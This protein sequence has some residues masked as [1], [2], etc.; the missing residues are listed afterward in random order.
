MEQE[1]QNILKKLNV[2]E[3]VSLLSGRDFWGTTIIAEKG[4]PG[5]TVT[6][7]PHG[8]RISD[9]DSDRDK[10]G[11]ATAFPT[12]VAMAST[13]NPEL[14]HKVGVALAEETRANKCDILL[15]P[16]INI[17]RTPLAGRNFETFSEDPYL[18]GQMGI[19]YVQ[20]VQSRGVGVSV[21][22]FA[23]NNQE[24]RRDKGSSN[25]DERTLR[26]IYL[27]A[28]EMIVKEADPWTIMCSYNR[29]NGVYASE[30]YHLLTEILKKEW[31]FKGVVV[32]DWNANHSTI[33]S[34][35]AGLDLEMPGPANYFGRHLEEAVKSWKADEKALDQAAERVIRLA[36]RVESYNLDHK[37]DRGTFS[38][39]QHTKL[40]KETAAESMVLLK[41]EKKNLPLD[42]RNIKKLAV[43]G[44][45]A[46]K[47]SYGGG[48]SSIVNCEYTISPLEGLENFY[49]E[50]AEI[51][52][53]RGCNDRHKADAFGNVGIQVS[54]QGEPGF[55]QEYFSNRHF[56][57]DPLQT[58]LIPKI[59]FWQIFT[60][61]GIPKDHFSVRWSGDMEVARTGL[62]TIKTEYQGNYQLFIDDKLICQEKE[63]KDQEPYPFYTIC[64]APIHLEEG[65]KYRIQLNFQSTTENER[66]AF[67]LKALYHITQ[68]EVDAEIDE[69]ISLAKEADIP[70]LFVGHTTGFEQEGIDRDDMRLPGEQDR[71]I[72][73]VCEAVPETIVILT[74]GSPVEMPWI[75][76]VNTLLQTHF[77]GQEGGTA[78]AEILHG[79]TNPSGKLTTTYPIRLKDNPT[80]I[81][82][83]GNRN[84][85]YGEGI[86]V[87]YR[88]YDFKE[89]PVLFPF[90]HGLSYTEFVFS[91]LKITGDLEEG[92][93]KA[94]FSIANTGD[95]AGAEVA[96]VYIGQQKC[97]ELR[98]PQE[99]KGFQKVYLAPGEK[100]QVIIHLNHRSFAY[101]QEWKQDWHR[102][103]GEFEI[104]VGNSSRN[105]LLTQRITLN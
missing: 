90:G 40:A 99:L 46:P 30:N 63:W 55:Y 71:L 65:K 69:A 38:N 9:E 91:D 39:D 14:I 53:H 33:E 58:D 31:G 102:D 84:H 103:T 7:G 22:H 68:K 19:G 13:W 95:K 80:Y 1:I 100:Q 85:N 64:K 35:E 27:P 59:D 23:A 89:M 17:V 36:K 43:L 6:D 73:R 67:I 61:E 10:N 42:P 11:T 62:Y 41:N 76:S 70:L 44:P 25:V 98:P 88:Y 93:L 96:Q 37:E 101:Y 77:Y 49:G 34:M 50:S 56:E 66:Q 8:V 94:E 47:A 32:S 4:I 26:E 54:H 28:F 104:R 18:A 83:S 87:G 45:C 15:G 52:Y 48:G 92:T 75:D 3:K 20:G 78:I 79:I 74:T 24:Y 16:C 57:G 86:F 60:P 5:V 51:L 2:K 81:H 29:I 82:Y 21:K 12:G 72:Q 97:T 105:I